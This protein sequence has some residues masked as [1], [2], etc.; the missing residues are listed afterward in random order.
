MVT[1]DEWPM[2]AK[3]DFNDDGV[4]TTNIVNLQLELTQ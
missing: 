2:P 3:R 4:W 1:L